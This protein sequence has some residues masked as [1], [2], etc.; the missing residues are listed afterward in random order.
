VDGRSQPPLLDIHHIGSGQGGNETWARGVLRAIERAGHRPHYAVTPAGLPFAEALT[1]GRSR[2]HLVSS[3][4]ALRLTRDLPRLIERLQPSALLIQYTPPLPLRV[5]LVTLVHDC[6][7]MYA[8]ARAWLPASSLTRY[9]LTITRGIECAQVLLVPTDWVRRDVQR[10]FAPRHEPPVWLAPNAVDEELA[11]AFT[12]PKTAATGAPAGEGTRQVLFVGNPLPRKRL[13]LA[14]GAVAELTR[15]GGRWR[16]VVAGAVDRRGEPAL[17]AAQVLL[18]DQ[19]SA[20][21]RVPA[22]ELARLY[23]TSD[24]LVYPS[25]SEGFGIPPVEAMA[26]GLPALVSDATCL[27]EVVGDGGLVVASHSPDAWADAVESAVANR[28]RWAAAGRVRAAQF[29]WD[30]TAATVMEALGLAADRAAP[31]ARSG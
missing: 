3:R 1:G 14:A 12:D 10:F 21:G 30:R 29:S 7:F 25:M 22:G 16:L 13:D 2:L 28:D 9:R 18:G 24:V 15:R 11:A 31:G 5:P 27:P 20:T 23:R 8:D 4:G 19:L 6:S 26:A 17:T